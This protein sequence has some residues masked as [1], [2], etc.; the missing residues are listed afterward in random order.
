MTITRRGFIKWL[1]ATAAAIGLPVK[2]VAEH[3]QEPFYTTV[4]CNIDVAMQFLGGGY[5]VRTTGPH[6]GQ[7]VMTNIETGNKH[8][9]AGEQRYVEMLLPKGREYK[10]LARKLQNGKCDGFYVMYKRDDWFE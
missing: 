7:F 9:T 2:A 3:E 4:E 1:G 8:K 5:Y 10:I 6:S